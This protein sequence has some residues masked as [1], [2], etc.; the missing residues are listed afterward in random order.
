VDVYKSF[1]GNRH[2]VRETL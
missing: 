1:K 2:L